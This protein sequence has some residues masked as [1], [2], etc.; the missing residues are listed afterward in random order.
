VPFRDISTNF[1][2]ILLTMLFLACSGTEDPWIIDPRFSEDLTVTAGSF[3][4]LHRVAAS[5]FVA[6]LQIFV[7][8]ASDDRVYS[9]RELWRQK[10]ML[11]SRD[12]TCIQALLAAARSGRGSLAG[13][14]PFA[15]DE[16]Y[17]MLA[18]DPE[19]LRVGYLRLY[20]CEADGR[21]YLVV[22]PVGDA[23]LLYSDR[24][25]QLLGDLEPGS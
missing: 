21:P 5:E 6:A 9:I 17:H 23:G 1:Q 3:E 14:D 24:L 10:R 20:A 16:V 22:R 19:L 11:E 15:S 18:F 2:T 12:R 7:T 13:C 25:P 8:P 4:A